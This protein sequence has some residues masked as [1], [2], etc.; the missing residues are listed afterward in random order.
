MDE[1]SRLVKLDACHSLPQLVNAGRLTRERIDGRY[2]Y[3]SSDGKKRQQQLIAR[4]VAGRQLAISELPDTPDF[5]DMAGSFMSTLDEH[6]R[7]LFA[8][9]EA[10]RQGYGGDRQ[11]AEFFNMYPHTVARG[12]K[13]LQSGEV[14][15]D[16]IRKSG[17]GRPSIEKKPEVMDYIEETLADDTAGEPTS[18]MK[19][20]RRTTAKVAALLARQYEILVSDRTVARL[21]IQRG[22]SLLVNHKKLAGADHP[23]RD[24]QF[25]RIAELRARSAH[26][27]IPIISIDTK[28][29]GVF[30]NSC[31]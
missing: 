16:R 9:Y 23:L 30:I 31:G 2:L 20:T 6:Q 29:K 4:K 1:F 11:V 13:E 27:Y 5:K 12:R 26:E 14:E 19:W 17:A 21:M 18:D 28:K 22:F 15:T 24:D 25:Q 10:V 8:G 7:R 3:C